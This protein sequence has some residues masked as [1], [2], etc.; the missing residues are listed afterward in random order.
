MP[1]RPASSPCSN[2]TARST[3]SNAVVLSGGSAFGLAAADGVM[4]FCEE[5]GIGF[6]TTAG[7]RADRRRRCRLY[8]LAVG[9][10]AVRPGRGRGLRGLHRRRSG[11]GRASARSAPATGATVGKWPG[12]TERRPG[13]LGGAVAAPRRSRRRR[14]GGRERRRRRRSPNRRARVPAGAGRRRSRATRP[15]ASSPPTPRLT[16]SSARCVA[17]SGHDGLAR[18][19]EPAHTRFDGDAV[20]VAATGGALDR[21]TGPTG[22]RRARAGR[23]R[24][25]SGHPPGGRPPVA[26]RRV[27]RPAGGPRGRGRAAAPSA[28]WPTRAAPRSCSASGDPDADLMFVGEGP[29]AEED[30]QGEP[31]VGRSGKLLDRLML[32]EIGIDRDGGA[33]SPTCVKCRPP[34]NRD[35][36]PDEIEACRPYLD[37]QLELIAPKVI[38]TLGPTSRPSCCWRPRRA[39]PSSGAGPTPSGGR[40]LVPTFHPAA[41][42]RGGG[43]PMAQ[44][45]ADLVRAKRAAGA[46]PSRGRRGRHDA[47]VSDAI[48]VAHQLGRRDPQARRRPSPSCA[49]PATSSC[50]P[51]ISAPARP[52]S[53]RASA[54]GLGVDEPITSPTF[55]LARQYQGRLA[56]HHLDVYRLEPA[57][58]G[59]RRRPARAA[60]RRARSSSSSG[61]TPSRPRCRPTTSRCGSP[62]ATATTTAVL[63]VP[64][65]SAA[66]GR[67]PDDARSPAVAALVRPSRRARGD[68]ADPRHR[69]R[70][71]PGRLRH[72]RPRGRAGPGPLGPRQAPRRDARRRRSSSSAARPGSSSREISVVAVDLGPASSPA[73]GSASPSAKAMAHALRV[74]MIGVPSLDLLAFP[75]R[76]T[77]APHRRR[78]STPAGA[79]CSTPSTA[80]CPA[81][82]SASP[83]TRSARP[84]TWRPSCSPGARRSCWSATAPSATP[85]CSTTSS[86]SRSPT[87]A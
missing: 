32:E 69:D 59:A 68:R 28:P 1:R 55:T 65:R 25:R 81:A 77:P 39:S 72:R 47:I 83:S 44:M 22:R 36:Q 14:A 20:V 7:H 62:S 16:S 73:C 48:A 6:A 45:R 70:D 37:S 38:V 4:R 10:A 57:R 17:Q 26:W 54:R 64:R 49:G 84:T 11:P 21:R 85:T 74:P 50:S 19:L 60:R 46:G 9:D 75:V 13:G 2:R 87:R 78:A 41:V 3:G 53:P 30:R 56:L 18:A 15:S 34:G 33:T 8:D 86:G 71:R 58:G 12:G 67:Q 35:P 51:A 80:R 42:L 66:A 52:P 29:G 23:G 76:F 5:R 43:E 82:C 31:F 63:D 40:V 79:R 27:E 61:A 24:G